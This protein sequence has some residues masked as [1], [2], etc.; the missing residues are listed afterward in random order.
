MPRE[1]GTYVRTWMPP[2][3]PATAS[4][5]LVVT[6]TIGTT[7]SLL[8]DDSAFACATG[9]S[10]VVPA[11]VP[12]PLVATPFTARSPTLFTTADAK[13]PPTPAPHGR[14]PPTALFADGMKRAVPDMT[15][16]TVKAAQAKRCSQKTAPFFET[17]HEV[18]QHR[19]TV[20][21]RQDRCM[22]SSI[23]EQCTPAMHVRADMFVD[24]PRA[25]QFMLE[26]SKL[27]AKDGCQ[28]HDLHAKQVALLPMHCVQMLQWSQYTNRQQL[29]TV[30]ILV[31]NTLASEAAQIRVS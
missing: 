9:S 27:S 28:R 12:A 8:E 20:S 25:V 6:L 13:A 19:L 17:V 16:G 11:P 3:Y 31:V 2:R 7:M 30:C 1:R 29:L 21:S 14:H 24:L 5:T 4:T 23:F 22:L 18:S 15:I 26:L 10:A